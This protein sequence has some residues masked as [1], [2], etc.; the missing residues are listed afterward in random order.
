MVW[1]IAAPTGST[2]VKKS[3]A[4][5]PNPIRI[6]IAIV[7][8]SVMTSVHAKAATKRMIPTPALMASWTTAAL[9]GA[10]G[11]AMGCAVC[12]AGNGLSL[13]WC[14]W[15]WWELA[16]ALFFLP[17]VHAR[18]VPGFGFCGVGITVEP[19]HVV[20]GVHDFRVIEVVT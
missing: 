16:V 20:Q 6:A 8:V 17:V 1:A 10:A 5:N 19:P 4:G 2:R 13:L 9:G 12:A 7:L 18:D 14:G 3:T 11:G 15:R